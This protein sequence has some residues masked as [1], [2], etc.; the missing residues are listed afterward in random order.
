[1]CPGLLLCGG[2]FAS[3]SRT[4][5]S[6]HR[7]RA[8]P[9]RRGGQGVNAP[10]S[11]VW[12]E[13]QISPLLL[14]ARCALCRSSRRRLFDR[15]R[16]RLHTHKLDG[17]AVCQNALLDLELRQGRQ[18]FVQALG[19]EVAHVKVRVALDELVTDAGGAHP[20]RAVVHF[21]NKAV[22]D[23]AS[24]VKSLSDETMQNPSRLPP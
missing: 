10:F 23:A 5:L 9:L 22:D 6:P 15:L 4:V 12:R 19:A 7:L 17:V 16:Y 24:R 2:R 21:I 8:E 3:G 18:E 13:G 1:M 20:A 14:F 11:A